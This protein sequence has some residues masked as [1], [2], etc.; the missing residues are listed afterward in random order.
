MC[1]VSRAPHTRH[2]HMRKRKYTAL[3]NTDT[4]HMNA[5]PCG[6]IPVPQIHNIVSTALIE[7]DHMPLDL[8]AIR[9][10][11][12]GTSYD[13]KRFAAM[14]IRMHN[15]TCTIL[16]FS[17]G[18]MVVTGG[19][20]WHESVCVCLSLRRLLQER[21][22]GSDFRVHRCAIE[23]I[24]AHVELNPPPGK[25]LNLD[26]MYT[27]LNLHCTYDRKMFPGLIYRPTA[28]PVVFLCFHSGKIV[29]TGGKS[30]SDV[31]RGWER[32]C[33]TISAFVLPIQSA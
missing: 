21:L 2:T 23:N 31:Y 28:F 29:I 27:H 24:V 33:P 17:S 26:A 7:S 1:G 25:Q 10:V 6:D 3:C 19:K 22:I 14:T 5:D 20:Y 32:M 8:D 15:P 11:I 30:T 18:R 13:K 4:P 9:Q 16:L 12:P